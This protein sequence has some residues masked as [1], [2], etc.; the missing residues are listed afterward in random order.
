M[1]E[2]EKEKTFHLQIVKKSTP[3]VGLL[4]AGISLR[5]HLSYYQVVLDVFSG[6]SVVFYGERWF[7][8]TLLF[9]E[10]VDFYFLRDEQKVKD[11]YL[12][13]LNSIN[14][15]DLLIVDENVGNHI[16][17]YRFLKKVNVRVFFTVHNLNH[18]LGRTFKLRHFHSYLMR[19]LIIGLVDSLIVISPNLVE[20]GKQMFKGSV[21]MLPF[22]HRQL[23]SVNISNEIKYFVSP[24]G[25][26]SRK[27]DYITLIN[28]F[29]NSLLECPTNRLVL[30]GKVDKHS[31][32]MKHIKEVNEEFPG[33]IIYWNNYVSEEEFDFYMRSASLLIGNI[34]RTFQNGEMFE[35]YGVT[36]ETGVLFLATTYGKSVAFPSFYQ[37][38]PEL[39]DYILRYSGE[40]DLLRILLGDHGF[41]RSS[42]KGEAYHMMVRKD[43]ESL[44][45]TVKTLSN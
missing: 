16:D 18:W 12:E 45:E 13:I 11:Y 20:F 36:K 17:F 9:G 44:Q 5:N 35:I 3:K 22:N 39:E 7:G 37:C 6:C 38:V 21:Y 4:C 29:Y 42:A 15:L 10:S 43:I 31:D 30:L 27:R 1:D 24:G 25:L 32:L 41:D 23:S 2:V 34:Q 8:S 28:S 26:D 33:R 40:G 14:R 19:R